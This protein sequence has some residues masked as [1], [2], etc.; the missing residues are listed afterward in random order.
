MVHIYNKV[1]CSCR[2]HPIWIFF[3]SFKGL[4]QG[5]PLSP[6]LFVF[7]VEALNCLLEGLL[8]GIPVN[9]DSCRSLGWG[10]E[11]VRSRSFP[12]VVCWWCYRLLWG[13]SRLD[14]SFKLI[15]HVVWSHLRTESKLREEWVDFDWKGR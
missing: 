13:F 8:A 14:D 10:V 11:E 2:W 5:D 1:L 9:V 6:Y 7:I 3:Q 4:R 15:V 12:F